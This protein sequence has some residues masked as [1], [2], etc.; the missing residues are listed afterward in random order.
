MA[1]LVGK[2]HQI[3]MRCMAQWSV[4]V[5]PLNSV[6]SAKLMVKWLLQFNVKMYICITIPIVFLQVHYSIMCIIQNIISV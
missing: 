1:H 6:K 5:N 3:I 2:G 4:K